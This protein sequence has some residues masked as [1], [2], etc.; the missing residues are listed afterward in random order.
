MLGIKREDLK[1]LG[2]ADF[3]IIMGLIADKARVLYQV[4]GLAPPPGESG[5][6]VEFLNSLLEPCLDDLRKG[7]E[8]A[9]ASADGLRVEAWVE[10][11]EVEFSVLLELF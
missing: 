7:E 2:A 4:L 3:G 8:S 6:L 10:E 1:D 9:S 11:G 5:D